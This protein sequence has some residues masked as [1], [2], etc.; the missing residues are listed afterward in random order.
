[1]PELIGRRAECSAL[2]E[3]IRAVHA[4]ESRALVVHGDPGVGKTALLEYVA[5]Q[6]LGCRIA[7]SGGV[8]SEMDLPF[9]GLHQL[10]APLLNRL[11][12]VPRPQREALRTVFGISDGPTPNGFQ[13]GLAVLSLL[14]SVAEEQPLICVVDDHQWL[15]TASALAL[16]FVA[17]RLGSESLGLVIATRDIWAGL[18][19]LP[20][21]EV[22]GLPTDAAEALLDRALNGPVDARIRHQIVAETGG[23]PL[24]LI[25]LPRGLTPTELA[26]GFGLPGATPLSHSIEESFGRRAKALPRKAR[27]LLLI[28][29]S[30]PSGDPALLWRAAAMLDI[31]ADAITPA[32]EQDLV[33]L[34]IRVRFSH[35]LAR[36]AV[37][38]SA[39]E[40]ERRQAHSALADATDPDLDPDRRAWHRAQAAVGPDED[41]AAALEHSSE[42]ARSRGGFAAAA[43]FLRRAASLTLDPAARVTRALV[44]AEIHIQAGTLDPVLDLLAMAE[45][46]PLNEFQSAQADLIRARL[47]FLTKRGSDSPTLL[48]KAASR[49]A[50]VDP[51]LSRATFLDAVAAA[52]YFNAGDSDADNR[53]ARPVAHL[54]TIASA[55]AMAPP[56][57]DARAHDLLLDGTV[58]VLND[59]Y[60][61]GLP[62]LREGVRTYGDGMT[63]ERQLHWLWFA[64]TTAMRIWDDEGWDALSTRH[65]QLARDL[66]S[67]SEL[68]RALDVRSL[69]CLFFG[70]LTEA[71]RLTHEART[72]EDATGTTLTPYG[73]LALAAFRGDTSAERSL[74]ETVSS[75]MR[76][77]E[78]RASTVADWARAVLY[79]GSGR[80]ADALAAARRATEF[81]A[82]PIS[83]LWPHV[84]L[85]EAAVRTG[86]IGLAEKVLD[87]LSGTTAVAGSDWALGAQFRSAA[88]L[89]ADCEAEELYQDSISHFGRTNLRVDH[90]RAYLLY[91][92]WLRRQRRLN[93]ARESLNTAYTM[94]ETM[95]VMAFAERAGRE[96]KAAG[97]G[98]VRRRAQASRHDELTAQEANIARMAR[99]G[100][101]NSEIAARLFISSH[102][103]QYHLG[104]V[105]LKLGIKSRSQLE[106]ALPEDSDGSP[107]P[108]AGRRP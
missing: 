105:F 10:C 97:G 84:E 81:D 80:Y 73:S 88:L 83:L 87:R 13:V 7:R 55:A 20:G 62:L 85:I 82:G 102:T 103:V 64:C 65:V 31:R 44:A 23:N 21:L 107:I 19:G 98:G 71:N 106:M 58:A 101:S 39:S 37:Y 78:D 59:G 36:S 9:A 91:G 89:A 96:L 70:N 99:V 33:E 77:Y 26:G 57:V 61:A 3:L 74:C 30:E 79:N 11:D 52:T 8:Q 49:L 75:G 66:G 4:G 40:E 29:A 104:K 43:A 51:E 53:D 56:T 25:E 48:M 32:V 17:R 95:G 67:L 1:M 68:P 22:R 47:G 54:W 94:F 27:E 63:A 18:S 28:A 92:E 50:R 38:R 34:G 90:A 6:A 5:V 42:R 69:L 15:D 14:S 100:L 24:A 60:A 76:E 86:D 93:E 108:P 46:G 35:P 45:A 72:I 2:N 16:A 12:R 41:V